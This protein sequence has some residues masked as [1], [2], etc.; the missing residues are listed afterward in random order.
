MSKQEKYQKHVDIDINKLSID[1]NDLEDLL[2]EYDKIKKERL[3][4][5]KKEEKCKKL[6][7]KLLDE[8]D[9]NTLVSEN[10]KITRKTLKRLQLSKE[11]MPVEVY[12][13]YA[14][15]VS[16]TVLYLSNK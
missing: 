6:V 16:Y 7:N 2:H 5:E 15:F 4:L 9:S 13:K 14:K 10:Y 8:Q 11:A 1:S 3:I 12:D